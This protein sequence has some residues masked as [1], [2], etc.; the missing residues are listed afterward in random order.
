MLLAVSVKATLA[1]I[2][3]MRDI[4]HSLYPSSG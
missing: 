4:F 1:T 2:E 3:I